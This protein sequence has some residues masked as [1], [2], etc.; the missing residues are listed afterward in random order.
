MLD[1]KLEG[2]VE[3]QTTNSDVSYES[4]RGEDVHEQATLVPTTSLHNGRFIVHRLLGSGG[5]GVVYEAF[6]TERHQSIAL[7]MMTAVNAS[8]IYRLKQEFR[9]LADVIHPNLVAL[10]ELFYD[11]NQW[12][13]TMDFVPGCTLFS[14]PD[15]TRDEEGLRSVFTQLAAGIQAIHDAGKL[16]RDLKPNNVLVTPKGR[17]VILDFGLTVDQDPGG[18]G[19]TMADDFITGT[20]R[21]M[22]PEQA[23]GQPASRVSDWYSFGVMLFEALT[24]RTPFEGEG[25]AVLMKKLQEDAPSPSSIKSGIPDDLEGLC[26]QLLQR[27][28]EARPDW[29]R[30]AEVL[31]PA[32][33]Q[34]SSLAPPHEAPFVG[35]IAELEE[36]H[37][38]FEATNSG[39][40]V[41]VFVH[42]VS[43]VG[44]ST[45][46]ERFVDD[47][48]LGGKAVVLTGRCYER[49]YVPFKACDALIDALSRYLKRLPREQ[50]AS[51]LPRNIHA[52]AQLF[53]ALQRLEILKKVKRRYPLPPDPNALRRTA[54][55]AFKEL[56]VNIASQE[57]LVLFVDD[58]QWGDVDG[59][60]LLSSLL[61]RPEPPPVLLIGA[62][63]SEEV[64]TSIGLSMLR[65]RIDAL[66]DADVRE[67]DLGELSEPESQKLAEELLPNAIQDRAPQI[68][69][70]AQGSP[71]FIT[72]LVRFASSATQSA[73]DIRLEDAIKIRSAELTDIELEVLEAICVS[74]RPIEQSFLQAVTNRPEIVTTL[75]RLQDEH[76]IRN[77]SSDRSNRFKSYHDKIRETVVAGMDLTRL[78]SWHGKLARSIEVTENPD[79]IALTEHL[80]D[81]GDLVKVSAAA[82]RAADYAAEILAFESAAKLYQIALEHNREGRDYERTLQT[83]L[84]TVLSNAGRGIEAAQAFMLAAE[85]ARLEDV[86]ELRE[87]AAQQWLISGHFSEGTQELSNVLKTVELKLQARPS[88]T[89]IEI[90]AN[91]A[92]LAVHGLNFKKR[93]TSEISRKELLELRACS[94]A[95]QGLFVTDT[96]RAAAFSSR[97]LW[98]ALKSGTI[99][100]IV[101]GLG[102]E[103]SFRSAEGGRNRSIVDG[104]LRECQRLGEQVDEPDV[105]AFVL[106]AQGFSAWL[107][108]E[109]PIAAQR[110][111]LA[112]QTYIEKCKKVSIYLTATR[113][114]LGS[115][116]SWLGEWQ[117]LQEKWNSWLEEAQERGD[118]YLLAVLT[119][120]LPGTY[121]CLATDRVDEARNQLS[122]GLAKWSWQSFD[123]FHWSASI[124]QSR[125]EL[126][127]GNYREAFMI[128]ES[129]S[130]RVFR[131]L[132]RQ[133]EFYRVINR[134]NLANAA[135]GLA[136]V[137][138][139]RKRLLEVAEKQ[140]KKIEKENVP[141]GYPY[142]PYIKGCI[143]HLQGDEDRAKKSLS[144]AIEAFKKGQFKLDA[145][146]TSRQLGR[147]LGGDKGRALIVQADNVMKKE[148]I[149]RPERV[150]AMLAPGFPD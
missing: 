73:T 13:F 89:V 82:N 18:A 38:A 88:A 80:L 9:A 108:G 78:K 112:E 117:K 11:Q 23:T 24:G 58:L 1:K 14:E 109:L 26:I 54:F 8:G 99:E 28:P 40:P 113:A 2:V 32:S 139:D 91:R 71:F 103:A 143:S 17:V 42:G 106:F 102:F 21:Y 57:P 22:A 48:R 30:I 75:R 47:L 70:E 119:L 127:S 69:R 81:A 85:G 12:F 27:N 150:A 15:K 16:H 31:G 5:M 98:L 76:L 87:K 86:L 46:V 129:T 107:L 111:Q 104:Y 36:L 124:C 136:S 128:A 6:D 123:L 110:L 101:F 66:E 41:V 115:C 39:R 149:V 52:V 137:S 120:Q 140:A 148:G 121:H 35:R 74:A 43:G 20:P 64:N 25:Q 55:S 67:I 83:K 118:L 68:V 29:Q 144:E 133:V 56:L 114:A 135:L 7:K 63:R 60:T 90:L 142:V 147:L 105:S 122:Q 100:N 79:L 132:L 145:A 146:A 92:K 138:P 34:L 33:G 53:P 131:S 93:H 126:Y 94:T 51:L 4:L 37:D 72:E 97:F 125:I 19:Q 96:L 61:S 141:F 44:K 77:V 134:V 116:Y 59:A 95:V 10:H 62:Y 45:L 49:E 3:T 65:A 130:K 84:G 50:A